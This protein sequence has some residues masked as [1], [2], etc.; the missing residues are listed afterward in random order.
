M[1]LGLFALLLLVTRTRTDGAAIVAGFTVTSTA[2]VVGALGVYLVTH[3]HPDPTQGRLLFEPIGYANAFGGLTAI[4]LTLLLAAAVS[5]SP[6]PS[7]ARAVAAATTVPALTALYL[8]QSRSAWLALV[9][10]VAVFAA[11]ARPAPDAFALL[12]VAAPA[13]VAAVVAA[14]LGIT[15]TSHESTRGWRSLVLAV[16][17]L[18]CSAVAFVDGRQPRRLRLRTRSVAPWLGPAIVLGVGAIGAFA[19]VAE[20][21][22][23]R[24]A[25]WRVAGHVV[26]RHLLGGAG[27]GSWGT[28]WLRLRTIDVSVKDAHSL[29]LETLSELGLIGFALL[30]TALA[31]PLRAFRRG[32]TPFTAAVG[33]SYCA[34]LVH[35][36]FEWDWEMPAV[37]LAGLALAA[38]LLVEVEAARVPRIRLAV[39]ARIVLAVGALAAA[40]FVVVSSVGR[41]ELRRAEHLAASGR[42]AE[43][44]AKAA[45]AERLL[46]WDSEPLTIRGDLRLRSGDVAGARSFYRRALDLDRH[47]W[48]L[49]LRLSLATSGPAATAARERAF[50]LDPGLAR[51]L[52]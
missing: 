14:S 8:T 27:A 18:G 48:Q 32:R 15:S 1:Y 41:A 21:T 36:G 43:A 45:S 7:Q 11:A 37:T 19:A 28:E 34:F 31:A 40:A 23:D 25:Y 46:S 10:G 50:A 5:E 47:D 16:A 33:G 4:L 20:G 22:G 38:V 13:A 29:Y 44:D 42:R 3:G 52:P 17:I 24:S 9:V 2:V 6:L 35:A 51:G 30:L 12:R 26:R 39:P 49:W